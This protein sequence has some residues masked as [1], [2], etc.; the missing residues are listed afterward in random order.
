VKVKFTL[1]ARIQFF[2]ALTYI[3]RDNP[4]AAVRFRKRAE[5]LLRRLEKFSQSGRALP[6]FP[7]LPYHE[8][9][10]FPYRLFYRVAEETVWIVAVWHGAQLPEEPPG[11]K[12]D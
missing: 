11:K 5:S 4:S 1:S 12:R 2:S 10:V 8:I 7:E 3:R 9:I 6:E